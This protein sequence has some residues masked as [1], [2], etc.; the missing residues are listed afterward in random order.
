LVVLNLASVV[1][2]EVLGDLLV[3]CFPL[4]IEQGAD[5]DGLVNVGHPHAGLY[6]VQ[7]CVEL[8]PP[9]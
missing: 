5:H 6:E 2:E 4:M 8:H 9:S 7:Q 3:I 1:C